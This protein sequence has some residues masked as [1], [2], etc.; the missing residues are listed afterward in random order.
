MGHLLFTFKSKHLPLQLNKLYRIENSIAER[1]VEFVI[2]VL[3]L[4]LFLLS[5]SKQEQTELKHGCLKGIKVVM[6][7]CSIFSLA[8][9][10]FPRY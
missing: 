6:P 7:L 3:S 9:F 5:Q 8:F 10:V 4:S 2:R 1:N